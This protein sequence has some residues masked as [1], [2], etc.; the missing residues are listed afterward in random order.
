VL[1][2]VTGLLDPPPVAATP[3]LVLKTA[4]DGAA[5]VTVIDWPAFVTVAVCVCW[6]AA[7]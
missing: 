1:E 3:K 7:L 2:K 4:E 5:V 6:A